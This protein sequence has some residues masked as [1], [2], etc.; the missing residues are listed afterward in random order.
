MGQQAQSKMKSKKDF[1]E[2]Y[3]PVYSGP[4]EQETLGEGAS[5]TVYLYRSKLKE[6]FAVK[7]I[8]VIEDENDNRESA[9]N[10]VKML[11]KLVKLEE[12]K[13]LIVKVHDVYYIEEKKE[14]KKK[15]KI[16]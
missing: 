6:Y 16:V 11:Q 15:G 8:P 14:F 1:E 7:V 2:V 12:C 9:D 3:S 10:E 4:D 13:N 5:G